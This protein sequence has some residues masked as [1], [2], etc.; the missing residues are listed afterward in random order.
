MKTV[1]QKQIE[2]YLKLWLPP[3]IWAVVIFSFSSYPTVQA[4]QI[5]WQ[6]FIVKKSFHIIEY[7]MLTIF[8]YRALKESGLERKKAGIY[9][10][11]FTILYGATDEFHQS[12]T[13][14]REAKARDVIFDTIG[15]LLAIYVIWKQLPKA[16]KKLVAWAK[17]LQIL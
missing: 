17:K 11:V 2:N 16:P 4:S 9:S 8:V 15:G 3:I 5:M 7:A 13:Q 1:I 12:F 14:G 10:I 6:D